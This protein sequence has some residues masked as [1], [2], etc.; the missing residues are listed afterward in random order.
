[1]SLIERVRQFVRDRDLFSVGSRVLAAVSGGSDSVA[2]AHILRELERAGDLQLAGLVHFNHQLRAAADDDERFVAQLGGVA[3]RAAASRTAATSPRWRGASGARSKTPRAPRATGFSSEARAQ[4]GADVDRARPHARRS[5]GNVPAAPAAR[6]R[7][8]AA[9]AACIRETARSSGR[10]SNAAARSCA[11]WLRARALPFVEDETNADVSIPRN[12]VRAELVPL[13]E[14]AVQPGHR[15]RAGRRGG[16]WRAK[17]WQ[18]MDSLADRARGTPRAS[19]RGPGTRTRARDGR[20]RL[21]GAPAGAA[22]GGAVARDDG[23]WPVCDRFPLAM[24]RP[25]SV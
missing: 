20:R 7:A 16:D 23:S 8:R 1:M 9:L 18:W 6:R 5:G 25:R 15:R 4:C 3:R 14:A 22:T 11:T 17:L 13:L 24:S 12:R 19:D 21:G 2:L 10:C